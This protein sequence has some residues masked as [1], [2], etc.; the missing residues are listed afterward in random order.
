VTDEHLQASRKGKLS[1]GVLEEDFALSI[2]TGTLDTGRYREFAQSAHRID[3]AFQA[4]TRI[5][6]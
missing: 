3:D 5:T 6:R 1:P 4:A 2:P